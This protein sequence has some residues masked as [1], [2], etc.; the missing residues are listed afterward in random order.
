M[1]RPTKLTPETSKAIVDA[2]AVGATYRDAAESAGVAYQTFLNW[3]Q[4]GEAA[5]RGIYF[6]FFDQ[7][8]RA[9]AAARLNFTKVITKAAADGDWRAAEAFLKRRDRATWG[10]NV[11]LT[12]G[13]E[14][15]PA[16]K[17]DDERFDRAIES[18]AKAIGAQ[19]HS[20]DDGEAG[21]VDTAE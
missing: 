17:V 3:M 15:L 11:D 9:E 10:D 13:G 1:P 19:I 21:R 4:A 16:P 18:L 7:V 14:K 20:A 5:K 6:E 8:R 2:L 12:S